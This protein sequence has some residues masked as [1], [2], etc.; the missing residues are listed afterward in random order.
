[1]G[2]LDPLLHHADGSLTLLGRALE[3]LKATQ[4]NLEAVMHSVDKWFDEGDPRLY[5]NAAT[6]AAEAR[7]IA[8]QAI[9]DLEEEN[10]K[11]REEVKALKSAI[12]DD[13][14]NEGGIRW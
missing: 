3:H 9:D 14:W 5:N 2:K 7:E 13:A 11:L 8:L 6:R 12:N 4:G 10:K 1:M